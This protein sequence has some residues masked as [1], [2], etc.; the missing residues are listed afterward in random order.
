MSFL[1]ECKHCL[2]VCIRSLLLFLEMR[3]NLYIIYIFIYN[4][5]LLQDP[6]RAPICVTECMLDFEAA[7]W[8]ALKEVYPTVRLLGCVYHWKQAVWRR[9]QE[10]GLQRCYAER[11]DV[12]RLLS[13][14]MALPYLPHEHIPAVFDYLRGKVGLSAEK[15]VEVCTVYLSSFGKYYRNIQCNR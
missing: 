15:L 2:F 13:K 7:T 11:S 14:L 4:F 6:T 10:A 8:A 5:L 9:I 1:S 3:S 12:Y